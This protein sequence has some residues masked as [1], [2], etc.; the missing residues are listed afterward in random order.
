MASV[1]TAAANLPTATLSGEADSD[2]ILSTRRSALVLALTVFLTTAIQVLV[3]PVAALLDGQ[4]EWTLV[5]PPPL[6]VFVL[7]LGC[8][9]Q[10][11]AFLLSARWPEATVLIV[12]AVYIGFVVGLAIPSWLIGMYLV[13]A[14]ALFFLASRKS[15]VISI[16]WL[17][18]VVVTT[19]GVLFLWISTLGMA[20][21]VALGYM[22]TE[23]VRIAA[24][25]TAATALGVWWGTQTR[26]VS[27]ARTQAEMAKREH[28]SRVEEAERR[29]RA[30]IAQELHDVA[31]QHLA[32]L[33]TLAGAALTI[34]P[35]RPEDALRLVEEVRDEGRFAAASL[36]GALGDL[37]AVGTA[38]QETT[39][40][41]RQMNELV[42]YWQKRGMSLELA[43][44]GSVEELPAVV[45]ATAYRCATEAITN[46][47]KHA[48]G[49]EVDIAI[50]AR[51][52]R[53]EVTVAN[54]LPP[55]GTHPIPGLGL[56]WGLSGMRDRID[57]L[58]G[59]LAFG[60]TPQGGWLVRFVIPV[61]QLD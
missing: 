10:A 46:A 19:V 14:L 60:T 57:L 27:L 21:S 55:S 31:G 13:I 39:R 47:A 5:L 1:D 48:P 54:Q 53:L 33:I 12:I 52:D 41:L 40:D 24:P 30:R 25:A 59:S 42:E 49:S 61:T 22:T 36:A 28:D 44:T 50:A 35:A 45:S 9:V 4:A 7:V 26:R 8:A 56:G 6:M 16:V 43:T 37:R 17:V 2:R 34:A 38:P 58:R 15:L 20:P 3:Q 51:S 29:E 11:S 32:G 23:A 18:G